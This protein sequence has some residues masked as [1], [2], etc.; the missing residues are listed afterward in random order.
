MA[1][2]IVGYDY[3]TTLTQAR[4]ILAQRLNDSSM[5]FWTTSEL[6]F[7]LQEALSTWNCYSRYFKCR[8][9]LALTAGT[10]TFLVANSITPTPSAGSE[11][12]I[13]TLTSGQRILKSILLHLLETNTSTLISSG[14]LTSHYSATILDDSIL[15]SLNNL[16]LESQTVA[17]S[18]TISGILAG[19]S[20]VPLTS[21]TA[22]ILRAEWQTVE[23]VVTLLTKA[24][25][26]ERNHFSSPFAA[27]L[28]TPTSYAIET[29]P[30]LQIEL[31]PTPDDSGTINLVTAVTHSPGT[32]L[33]TSDTSYVFPNEW[34]WLVKYGALAKL[35]STD[36]PTNYPQLADYCKKRLMQG[37]EMLRAWT[38][39]ETAW[40]GEL[41]VEISSVASG[42]YFRPLWKTSTTTKPLRSLQM[43]TANLG[44]LSETLYDTN[45][46]TTAPT[47]LTLDLIRDSP[48]VTGDDANIIPVA[49]EHLNYLLDYAQHL[50]SHKMGGS[51]FQSTLPLFENFLNGASR[52]NDKLQA[53]ILPFLPAPIR[54]KEQRTIS[55][56]DQALTADGGR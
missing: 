7:Y 30:L 40:A 42:D 28:G 13:A 43:I 27:T 31:S 29:T 24:S 1:T 54:L 36:G 8:A 35:Y 18:G 23:G 3:T 48:A 9:T 21:S 5:V 45:G 4:S 20:K 15:T 56:V 41:P 46:V 34:W 12:P 17:V 10:R 50:A 47:T 33:F 51:E 19:Q 32:S 52:V 44:Y 11:S 26:F 55:E 25:K 14:D 39:I 38:Y 37:I 22:N 2:S 6:D 53:N 49:P 16:I